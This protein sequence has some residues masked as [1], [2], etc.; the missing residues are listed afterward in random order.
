MLDENYTPAFY[1]IKEFALRISVHPNTVRN[2]IK[3]G[4]ISAFKVG[5]GKKSVYRIPYAETER[6]ALFDLREMIEKII[7]EKNPSC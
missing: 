5:I 3:N 6:L 1:S 4:R 2:A 7:Q